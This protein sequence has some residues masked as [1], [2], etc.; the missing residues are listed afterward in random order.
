MKTPTSTPKRAAS[1]LDLPH[2]EMAASGQHFGDD[3]LAA[4]LGE[5][6][7]S[8]MVLLHEEAKNLDP[9]SF[10]QTVFLN[11]PALRLRAGRKDVAKNNPEPRRNP[12]MGSRRRRNPANRRPDRMADRDSYFPY[13]PC[14]LWRCCAGRNPLWAFPKGKCG[15]CT[16]P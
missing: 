4:D 3:A 8:E 11:R 7:L 10:R 6:S 1:A 2:V 5:V 9:G 13:T 16:K 15:D 12:L 14:F